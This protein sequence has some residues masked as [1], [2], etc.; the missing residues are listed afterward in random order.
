MTTLIGV[1]SEPLRWSS[2]SQGRWPE[3]ATEIVLSRGAAQ[4]LGVAVGDSL[5]AFGDTRFTVVGLTDEPRSLFLQT[6]YLAPAAFTAQGVDPAAGV[7]MWIIKAATG[8]TPSNSPTPC[9]PP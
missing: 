6:G 9:A 5:S 3:A 8:T 4:S 2:I 7:G 1:P